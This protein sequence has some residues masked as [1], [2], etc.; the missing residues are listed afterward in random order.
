MSHST[1]VGFSEPPISALSGF[2]FRSICEEAP[3]FFASCAVGVGYCFGLHTAP[4]SVSS[5]PRCPPAHC[6]SSERGVGYIRP[7]PP[8]KR[9][10]SVSDRLKCA[11]LLSVFREPLDLL[12]PLVGVGHNPYSFAPVIGTNVGRADDSPLRIEPHLGQVSENSSKPPSNECCRVLHEH[13]SRSYFANDP[14]HFHPESAALAVDSGAATGD[15]DVL[16]RE[17]AT[18]H[19]NSASPSIPV[20]GSDVVPNRERREC[21]VVLSGHQNR[22][23]VGVDLDGADA[24]VSEQFAAENAATSACE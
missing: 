15:A 19:F 13:E 22:S 24:A 3:L 9:T 8:S 14:C 21:P 2:V 7:R 12:S 10:A 17:S 18:H 1:H 23:A 5:L 20:K 6:E 11:L 16:A 4:Y